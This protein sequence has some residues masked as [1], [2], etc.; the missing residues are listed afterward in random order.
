MELRLAAAGRSTIGGWIAG[1][2]PVLSLTTTGRR[3]A[4][5]H[6]TPVLFHRDDDGSFLVI[7][8]N[9]AAD[10]NPDWFHNLVS[11]PHVASRLRGHEPLG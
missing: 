2:V 8:A 7:A 10:W 4:R 5:K 9:G 6:T 11:D 3:S 1:D